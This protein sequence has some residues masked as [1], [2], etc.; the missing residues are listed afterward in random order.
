MNTPRDA[1]KGSE[2]SDE[3]DR[4]RE[5]SPDQN[6]QYERGAFSNNLGRPQLFRDSTVENIV[7]DDG[8]EANRESDTDDN[9]IS[10]NDHTTY[11]ESLSKFT[12]EDSFA[13]LEDT[14]RG[15]GYPDIP[16][17]RDPARILSRSDLRKQ[18]PLFW[19]IIAVLNIGMAMIEVFAHTG[20]VFFVFI[21]FIKSKDFLSCL[22]SVFGL[23][24]RRIY[25]VFRPLSPVSRQWILT[26]IPAYSE[27]EEQI[28]KII[29]LLRD[30]DVGKHRQVM[31]V[32]LDGRPRDIRSHMTRIIRDYKRTYISLKHKRGALKIT[33][34]FAEDVPVIV[35]EKMRNSGKKDS[36]VLCHDLFNVPR[37]NI[38]L[39]TRLL[40]EEIW[41]K[42]LPVL[43]EGEG[44]TTCL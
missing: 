5:R 40:R 10:I 16:S 27:S 15:C 39:Y 42:I 17:L 28:V 11:L 43:T 4:H 7:R 29:Y 18:R 13:K 37:K 32:L 12:W 1:E 30:N 24:I 38:P 20:L 8:D 19:G 6:Q 22:V 23:L 33:A 31:V 36:L 14:V 21:L 9:N 41:T 35:I 25:R 44:F 26:L 34:G 2:P 3:T